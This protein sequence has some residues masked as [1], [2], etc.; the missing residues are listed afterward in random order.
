[1]VTH[2]GTGAI[3]DV[4]SPMTEDDAVRQTKELDAL[5][6]WIDYHTDIRPRRYWLFGKRWDGVDWWKRESD[7]LSRAFW[8]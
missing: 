4:S 8:K 6:L 2:D 7:G 1:M 3:V 5:H